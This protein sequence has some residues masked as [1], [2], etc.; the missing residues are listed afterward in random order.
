MIL[1]LICRIPCL[2]SIHEIRWWG[3]MLHWF[4]L[5]SS[6]LFPI[7]LSVPQKQK[8]KILSFSIIPIPIPLPL[9]FSILLHHS[10]ILPDDL[11]GFDF[12]FFFWIVL[13]LTL[14]KELLVW[15]I[16][17]E[18]AGG[19]GVRID[20]PDVIVLI[21]ILI[22]MISLL[23]LV[24]ILSIDLTLFYLSTYLIYWSVCVCVC[25]FNVCVF[26]LVM[27]RCV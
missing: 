21:H 3:K 22:Y 25:F 5:F 8:K 1:S 4:P 20:L 11:F 18:G 15:T 2:L 16:F 24:R 27:D 26:F 19:G 23:N 6:S 9:V 17:F 14:E 12:F 13:F 7:V 10:P